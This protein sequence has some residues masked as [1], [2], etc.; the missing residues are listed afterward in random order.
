MRNARVLDA[1]LGTLCADYDV[2]TDAGLSR[3]AAEGGSLLPPVCLSLVTLARQTATLPEHQ[4]GTLVD[5][6]ALALDSFVR[7]CPRI[8]RLGGLH[9]YIQQAHLSKLSRSTTLAA[10]ACMHTPRTPWLL[11]WSA[12]P[13]SPCWT[14]YPFAWCS[15]RSARP[16]EI[17]R[18]RYAGTL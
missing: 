10:T 7:A 8:R 16:A 17:V 9:A 4:T 5:L 15:P 12:L 3:L 1:A 11:A 2:E 13:W 14:L 18:S 6:Y